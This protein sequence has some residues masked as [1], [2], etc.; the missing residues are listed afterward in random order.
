MLRLCVCILL[1]A[2]HGVKSAPVEVT[3]Q[4]LHEGVQ[5]QLA[6]SPA[7]KVHLTF[8]LATAIYHTRSNDGRT[9]TLPVKIAELDKLVLRMRSGPRI[10]ATNDTIRITAI[11]HATGTLHGWG[12][13]DD[14]KTWRDQGSLNSIAK[15]ARE[16]MHGMAG[17][18]L[19]ITALAW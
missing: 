4:E 3:P 19:G 6:I 13:T 9:F 17:N 1:T 11:S 18:G 7:G 15:S 12:S 16:G 14:G 8:G 2:F 10:A 5:P